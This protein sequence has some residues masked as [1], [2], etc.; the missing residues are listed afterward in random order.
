MN[1]S[2]SSLRRHWDRLDRD[3]VRARQLARLRRFL[4]EVVLPFSKHYGRL[5]AREGL[6]ADDIRSWDD[7][8]R[9]PFTSKLDLLAIPGSAAKTRDFV[10][11]PDPEILKRRPS[12]IWK[13]I[14]RGP[15]AAKAA[16]ERE[17]RPI[18]MTSTTGRSTD[19]V[20]FLYTQHDLDN[21]ETAGRRMMEICDSRAEWK[22]LN[23]FPFAPH[24]AFWQAHYAGLGYNTFCLSTGGGK[25]MGTDGNVRLL[26]KIQPDALIGMPTFIY[27]VL[28]EAVTRGVKCPTLK[29]IVLGGE[30]VPDGMRRKLR[31]MSADLG[32]REVAVMATY[33][34]TEARMAWPECPFAAEEESGGYHLYPDLGLV[35]VIDPASGMPVPD[36]VGGEIVFTPLDARGSVVLRYRTGDHISGGLVHEPCPRC[37]R[38]LPRLLG[39]IS[40]VSD[41]R[42]LAIDKIKGTLVNFNDLENMLDDIDAIGA[43]Q[44]ELRKRNDD[45]LDFDEIIVHVATAE[46]ADRDRVVMAIESRFREVTEISPNRIEF[47]DAETLRT[48]QGVGVKLKEDKV[49]DRRNIS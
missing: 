16:L 20:P 39:R 44:I 15:A 34:F 35:E 48:M 28:Q 24:L 25:V 27:H 45:P 9:V 40:R 2:A 30:K 1:L 18:L 41:V 19:P 13:A 22:H 10:L 11:I 31:A 4:R 32:S 38:R 26:D 36:G 33:G 46:S 8:S 23:L 42:E 47:H 6:T 17:Y 12:T 29:R 7:W 37:G 3:E 14:T 49:I 21:L 5:F 43:W